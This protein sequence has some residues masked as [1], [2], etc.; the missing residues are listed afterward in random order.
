MIR[1]L[2]V[3]DEPPARRR[4]KHLLAA[5]AD[6]EVVA[7][8]GTGAE[9]IAAAAEHNPDLI[10]LDI[11]LPDMNGFG[12]LERLP[13]REQIAV[14]FVTAYDEHAL[15]AF[16][17][18]AFDYLL[19]PVAADRFEAAIERARLLVKTAPNRYAR[20]FLVERGDASIFVAVDAVDWF[21][22][23]R[24][25]VLMHVKAETFLMRSTLDSFDRRLHPEQFARVNRSAIVNV[26]RIAELQPWTNGEYRIRMKDST[27]EIMWTR[28]FV[29]ASLKRLLGE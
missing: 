17:A 24:N 7:E 14:M 9:A 3:D 5:Y 21:E 15:A 6:F 19:K 13:D 20:R 2:I 28:R 26:D 29:N 27:S 10:L 12:V 11:Q 18:R 22:S 25:Y 4:L 1:V 8:A 16:E 23:A